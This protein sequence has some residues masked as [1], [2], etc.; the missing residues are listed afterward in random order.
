MASKARIKLSSVDLTLLDSMCDQIKDIA[1]KL[2]IK[3]S[4]PIPLP[5]KRMKIPVRTAPSGEGRESYET[6]EMR[7]HKRVLDIAANEKALRH[8][9]RIPIPKDVHI[10]MQF[11]D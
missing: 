5:I 7:V 10:E 11:I 6:W 4:G 2:K 8:I 9:M 3:V 1:K